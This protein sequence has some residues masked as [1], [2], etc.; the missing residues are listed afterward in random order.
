[1]T[2]PT[3]GFFSSLPVYVM[4]TVSAFPHPQETPLQLLLKTLANSSDMLYA[5]RNPCISQHGF[6]CL[7]NL[8]FPAGSVVFGG[9]HR[10]TTACT[11]TAVC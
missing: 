3:V 5:L 1:M 11:S 8:P 7:F 10:H 6:P 9:S 4:T 2:E